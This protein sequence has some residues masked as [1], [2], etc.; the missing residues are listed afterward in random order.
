VDAFRSCFACYMLSDTE[1]FDFD[2]FDDDEEWEEYQQDYQKYSRSL[3]ESAR[4]DIYVVPDEEKSD[5]E[6]QK[7]EVSSPQRPVD[8]IQL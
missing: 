7:V 2:E 4:T 8:V 1:Y 6:K 3:E 5:A